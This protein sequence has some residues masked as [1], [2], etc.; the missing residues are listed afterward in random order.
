MPPISRRDDSYNG[1]SRHNGAALGRRIMPMRSPTYLPHP[2]GGADEGRAASSGG[3]VQV[4]YVES[5]PVRHCARAGRLRVRDCMVT[6]SPTPTRRH[7]CSASVRPTRLAPLCTATPDPGLAR[8]AQRAGFLRDLEPPFT[9]RRPY[10]E[11]ARRDRA[12]PSRDRRTF[13]AAG[14]ARVTSGSPGPLNR[15]LGVRAGV[16][17]QGLPDVR[18]GP[19]SIRVSQQWSSLAVNLMRHEDRARPGFLVNDAPGPHTG[20]AMRRQP[21]S[22]RESQALMNGCQCQKSR[23]DVTARGAAVFGRS[24]RERYNLRWQGLRNP[25]QD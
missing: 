2:P 1:D 14:A 7:L 25:R 17:R 12:I 24:A 22:D 19:R 16:L 5:R 15:P 18:I 6:N 8:E 20:M 11:L 13:F 21:A 9:S 3:R 23:Q 4:A 10:T